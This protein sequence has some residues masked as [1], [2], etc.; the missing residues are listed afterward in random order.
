MA[1]SGCS[2]QTFSAREVPA[3][4]RMRNLV[5]LHWP[6]QIIPVTTGRSDWSERWCQQH[7]DHRCCG[8]RRPAEESR[9]LVKVRLLSMIGWAVFVPRA[10]APNNNQ[11]AQPDLQKT[12]SLK[13][14]GDHD[15]VPKYPNIMFHGFSIDDTAICSC[16][17]TSRTGNANS[18]P[19][20]FAS[21]DL[22]VTALRL[23]CVFA[24]LFVHFLNQ[25]AAAFKFDSEIF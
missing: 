23:L 25:A 13:G 19:A 18:T 8:S 20:L 5:D 16:I 1:S 24:G 10:P 4:I 15:D 6:L 3:R 2:S 7:S 17:S 21:D 22:C 11:L 12:T 14:G 9:R